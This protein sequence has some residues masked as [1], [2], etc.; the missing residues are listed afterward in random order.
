MSKQKLIIDTDPGIDDAMAIHYA[1]A[2][3][4]LDLIGLTTIFG[5]V[6]VEQATRNAII[7]TDQANRSIPVSQG[8]ATPLSMPANPPSH[9]VHGDEGFGDLPAMTPSRSADPRPAHVFLAET[10]RA[11]PGEVIL[12]PIGPLTNIARLLEYAPDIT[13]L[14]KKVVIMGGAVD[15]PGN[16]TPYAEANIW[17]DPH[18]ADKVFAANWDMELIGLDVTSHIS[19]DADDFKHL[20]SQAPVI[21]GF[22]ERVSQF[23]ITFY[24]SIIG[25]HIC[26][27][28]DP[29]AVVSITNPAVFDYEDIPLEVICSGERVGATIPANATRRPVKVAKRVDAL[30]VQKIFLDKCSQ[31]DRI[32]IR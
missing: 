4:A 26:L 28:H 1:F 5:N 17:N 15:C 16:V 21:G 24:H 29:S 6:F 31:S 10:I 14:V 11:F 27:M 23:Y 8:A 2:H 7:L 9:Y 22:L 13:G 18:A 30:S 25:R 12:C 19:C 32:R 20:A 3:E